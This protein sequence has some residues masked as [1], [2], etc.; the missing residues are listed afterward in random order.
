MSEIEAY[1][2]VGK[3]IKMLKTLN[4]FYRAKS[5][6]LFLQPSKAKE[7]KHLWRQIE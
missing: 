4:V 3:M 2:F 7:L 5:S 6:K 1:N